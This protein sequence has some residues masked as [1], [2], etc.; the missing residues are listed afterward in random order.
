MKLLCKLIMG[1]IFCCGS[2][3]LKIQ[4]AHGRYMKIVCHETTQLP[5]WAFAMNRLVIIS[6]ISSALV[7]MGLLLTLII[8]NPFVI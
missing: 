1:F 2:L 4:S 5:M 3:G 6:I 7:S 8:E